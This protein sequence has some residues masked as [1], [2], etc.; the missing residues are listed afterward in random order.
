MRGL[1]SGDGDGDA[2]RIAYGL[3][4][5]AVDA[6]TSIRPQYAVIRDAVNDGAGGGAIGGQRDGQGLGGGL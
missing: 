5:F 2:L 1:L 4:G 3:K 6:E